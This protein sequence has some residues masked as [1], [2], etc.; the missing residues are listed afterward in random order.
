M[1]Y[2][3]LNTKSGKM[4]RTAKISELLVELGLYGIERQLRDTY[5]TGMYIPFK[6]EEYTLQRFKTD[7]SEGLQFGKFEKGVLVKEKQNK[8]YKAL[9]MADLHFKYEDKASVDILYQFLDKHKHELHEIVDGGDGIDAS[10]LGKHVC[11]EEEKHDLYS[12]MEAYSEHMNKLKS[13]IPNAKFSI[14]ECNHYYL[15]LKRFIAENP[16]MKNMIKEVKFK[17]DEK[18]PH[19]TPYFPLHEYGQN[20]IAGIHGIYFNDNF[21][22]KNTISYNHDMFQAHTHTF[23]AYKADNQLTSY[24]IPCMCKKEMAYLQGR[25]NRWVNGF[26]VLS[27][28][29]DEERYALEFCFV[30][31]GVGVYRDEVYISNV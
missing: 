19:G 16:A 15:R 12:E 25:P 23:Q 17:F 28:F 4:W 21:T 10:S 7:N 30:E 18:A 22:K 31:N 2:F 3:E 11:T 24:G 5:K 14:L 20:K 6:N 29:P 8:V 26:A 13:I 1:K 27:W 9:I